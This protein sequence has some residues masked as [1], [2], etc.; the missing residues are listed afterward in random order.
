MSKST[1]KEKEKR[2][3]KRTRSKLHGTAERPRLSVYRSLNEIYVQLINDNESHTIVSADSR[4]D[5]DK[6]V[7]EELSGKEKDAYLVGLKVA[8]RAQEEG[9]EKVVFDRGAYKYHGRVKA[10]AEGARE[11]G[12]DF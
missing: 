3:K 7:G 2:R 10:L 6:E 12:L 8:E 11:S 9:I 4:E 1:T 5:I